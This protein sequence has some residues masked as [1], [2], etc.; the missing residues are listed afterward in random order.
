MFTQEQYN[1]IH[2]LAFDPDWPGYRPHIVES[3]Q[4]D[5]K[6][7]S[8]KRY[9]HIM[10]KYIEASTDAKAI[11]R[12]EMYFNYAF[13]VARQVAK[14][15]KLPK[16][17]MPCRTNCAMRILEYQ[18]GAGSHKHTDFNLFTLMMY[19]NQPDKFIIHNNEPDAEL[20]KINKQL[21]FGELLEIE[22][23]GEACEHSVEP[24]DTV[25]HSIVFFAIPPLDTKLYYGATVREYLDERLSRS[26]KEVT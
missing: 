20:K 26:R 16:E 25:Q 2:K 15:L 8:E 24:S 23:Y 5:G 9:A 6:F 7:D 1:E 11:A 13:S 17:L 18:P 12:L 19:R 14:K 22:G 21:H 4:G 10:P 3:P